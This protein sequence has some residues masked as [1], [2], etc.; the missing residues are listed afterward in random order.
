M[1]AIASSL[2][3]LLGPT[4][5]RGAAAVPTSS[6]AGTEVVGLYFSAHWC[7]PCRGFTPELAKI[8]KGVVAGGKKMEIPSRFMDGGQLGWAPQVRWP[9]WGG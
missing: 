3:A 1:A 6:L 5:R 8:Y 7:P 2:E 4:L 9:W